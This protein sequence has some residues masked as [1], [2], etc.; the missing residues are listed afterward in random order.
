M[1]IINF[2]IK[3]QERVFSLFYEWLMW[4]AQDKAEV[5]CFCDFKLTLQ[6]CFVYLY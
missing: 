1:K 6:Q 5:F 3:M 2:N 4:D